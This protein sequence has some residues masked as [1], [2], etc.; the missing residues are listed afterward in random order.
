MNKNKKIVI[1]LLGNPLNKRLAK[2]IGAEKYKVAG[3]DFIIFEFI[4]N[5]SVKLDE[6]NQEF[7][8]KN[9]S[10]KK[11]RSL[12]SFRKAILTLSTS[13]LYFIDGGLGSNLSAWIAR[14]YIKYFTSSKIGFLSVDHL[15]KPEVN[16]F[17]DAY[18]KIRTFKGLITRLINISVKL[19]LPKNK[20][21]FAIV[22]GKY[23]EQ[24][25][26]KNNIKQVIITN[27]ADVDIYNIALS[28]I[29]NNVI[30]PNK[31]PI[32]VFLDNGLYVHPDTILSHLI[33]PGNSN[34]YINQLNLALKRIEE[35]SNQNLIIAAH[36]K[37]SQN[38][39]KKYFNQFSVV[40][41]KTAELVIKSSHVFVVNSA[42]INFA[43]LAGKPITFLTNKD[44]KKSYI[45][46]FTKKWASLLGAKIYNLENI[47]KISIKNEY[48]NQK[49]KLYID[50]FL[51]SPNATKEICRWDP[52]LKWIKQD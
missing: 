39:Y 1:F 35:I 50:E 38:H 47:Q 52:V 18:L 29:R 11:I 26:K 5:Y 2:K 17:K 7:S 23:G 51:K 15:P 41:G 31:K 20:W 43:V 36:P 27:A 22:A 46:P 44:I 12:I 9:Y 28:T 14:S 48:N 45:Y 24:I 8:T 10:L 30:I 32:I 3:L 37:I 33:V 13:N 42:S 4:C 16:L 49:Y 25:A 19:F 40:Y 21:D 34:N 6:I